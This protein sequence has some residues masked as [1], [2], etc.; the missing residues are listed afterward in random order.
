MLPTVLES[1]GKVIV[2]LG[3]PVSDD[4]HVEVCYSFLKGL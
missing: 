3:V 1:L 2:L 4:M